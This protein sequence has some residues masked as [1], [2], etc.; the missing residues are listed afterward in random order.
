MLR[1]HQDEDS[2]DDDEYTTAEKSVPPLSMMMTD[3]IVR[4]MKFY[5]AL[6]PATSANGAHATSMQTLSRCQSCRPN[7]PLSFHTRVYVA[8][9]IRRTR[10]NTDRKKNAIIS[11][12]GIITR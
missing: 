9:R 7:S 4:S 11:S 12:C 6:R 1:N 8:R 2:S 5:N 10:K 3:G